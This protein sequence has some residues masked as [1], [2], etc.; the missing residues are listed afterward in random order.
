MSDKYIIFCLKYVYDE[1]LAVFDGLEKYIECIFTD[2]KS[3][4]EKVSCYRFDEFNSVINEYDNVSKVV[5]FS[6]NISNKLI[7]Y[8]DNNYDIVKGNEWLA[9]ML[10]DHPDILLKPKQLRIEICT[11]CQ[12]KCT[13]CYMRRDNYG[14]V[15]AG[16]MKFEQF[17]KVIEDYPYIKSI[18]ISNS[19]EPLLNPDLIEILKYSY[20]H[21]IVIS[22]SNGTNF[23]TASDELLEAFVKYKVDNILMSI[24]GASSETYS[25]YR[26]GGN[27]DN[28]IANIKKIN[29]YKKKYNSVSPRLIYKSILF[30]HNE[31]EIEKT[32]D[33]AKELECTV[34]FWPPWKKEQFIPKNPQKVFELTGIDVRNESEPIFYYDYCLQMIK[35][36]QINWDGRVLGCCVNY[37]K[38]WNSNIFDDGLVSA[39]NTEKYRNAICRFLGKEFIMGEDQCTLYCNDYNNFISKG[40]YVEL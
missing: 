31:H 22:I 12:L 9:Q 23:N 15:G 39:I 6:R 27:F 37:L 16:Y 34:K 3:D 32:I 8:L 25:I 33:L 38:D 28:V 7:S 19:G 2:E 24:D 30:T 21:G 13:D 17:K 1:Y 36:P 11:L 4:S 14:S 29:E 40:T 35:S 5:V 10:I 26:E 18:E 20:E